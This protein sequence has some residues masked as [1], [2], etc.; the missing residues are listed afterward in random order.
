MRKTLKLGS[1]E[2]IISPVVLS[3]P[4]VR[5]QNPTA[6]REVAFDL[7]S[8]QFTIHLKWM[9]DSVEKIS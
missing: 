2:K 9:F 1:D 4:R 8:F 3:R 6:D 5:L 7:E